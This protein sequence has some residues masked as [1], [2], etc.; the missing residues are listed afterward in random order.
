MYTPQSKISIRWL[1]ALPGI[2]LA[3][4]VTIGLALLLRSPPER[5]QRQD[6]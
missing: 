3:A 6:G 5:V 4:V 1:S 2:A